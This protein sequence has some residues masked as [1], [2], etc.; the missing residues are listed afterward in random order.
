M[1]YE[2]AKRLKDAGFPQMDAVGTR[3]LMPGDILWVIEND[4]PVCV[5]SNQVWN[6]DTYDEEQVAYL[7]TL[8]ELIA[9]CGED[10]MGLIYHPD[11]PEYPLRWEAYPQ[12]D[13][14]KYECFGLTPEAAVTNLWLTLN[15]KK[16]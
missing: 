1:K 15:E 5:N 2:L 14:Y 16:P 8:S 3:F 9:E 6:E 10:F 11:F 7:P 4:G 13:H 12:R